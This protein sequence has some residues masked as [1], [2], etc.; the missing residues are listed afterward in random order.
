MKILLI[1]AT[2]TKNLKEAANITTLNYAKELISRGHEVKIVAERRQGLPSE[3]VFQGVPVHRH[4]KVSTKAF[5]TKFLG[6]QLTVKEIKKKG[7]NAEVVHGFSA[8]T[9]MALNT[10]LAHFWFPKSKVFHTIKSESKATIDKYFSFVLNFLDVV[11]VSTAKQVKRLR[12]RGVRKDKIKVIK[13]HIDTKKFVAKD[14]ETLKKSYGYEGRKIVLY[15]GAMR[16]DKGT[17]DLLKSS[18]LVI[19]DEPLVL[20]IFIGRWK[21]D[22]DEFHRYVKEQKLEENVLIITEDVVIEDYVAMADIGIFPYQT[23]TRTE[24]NP[25]CVLECLACKTPVITSFLPELKEILTNGKNCVMVR[26]QDIKELAKATL[27]LLND[28]QKQERLRE[29]GKIIANEFSITKRTDEFLEMYL[30]VR[31][32]VNRNKNNSA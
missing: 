2:F 21:A 24:S 15:Y 20:Y 13:S 1:N 8:S 16:E 28:T 29:E 3:E 18:P 6:L 11:T 27:D 19:K 30:K 25:S 4:K 31:G 23:L 9:L 7:F 17:M 5:F 10:I 26:P 12:G 32:K 22:D 14:K